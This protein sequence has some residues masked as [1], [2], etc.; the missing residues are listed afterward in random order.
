[1]YAIKHEDASDAISQCVFIG[2]DILTEKLLARLGKEPASVRANP[3]ADARRKTM[4][5]RDH[6]LKERFNDGSGKIR[7]VIR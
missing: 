5:P 6:V 1:M 4:L 2:K 3:K 7:R